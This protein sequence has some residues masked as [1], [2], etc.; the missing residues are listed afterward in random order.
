MHMCNM[1]AR[2]PA[3]TA[4]HGTIQTPTRRTIYQ[5]VRVARGARKM[6]KTACYILAWFD[7]RGH[8]SL[9]F[10]GSCFSCEPVAKSGGVASRGLAWYIRAAT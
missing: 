10:S 9:Y 2:G 5:I 8:S 3:T 4:L 1:M 7:L 6:S